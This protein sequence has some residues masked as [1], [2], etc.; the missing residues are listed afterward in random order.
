M[1]CGLRRLDPLKEEE[2]AGVPDATACG[3]RREVRLD[4]SSSLSARALFLIVSVGGVGGKLDSQGF[5]IL[6]Q[7]GCV[8]A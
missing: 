6:L 1:P 2:E 5:L 8:L 7:N 3:D 4:F